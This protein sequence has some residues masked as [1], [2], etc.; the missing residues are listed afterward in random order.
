N[1]EKQHQRDGHN[2]LYCG[3]V[4]HDYLNCHCIYCAIEKE[5]C[6]HEHLFEYGYCLCGERDSTQ[7][8][9]IEIAYIN[10]LYEFNRRVNAGNYWLNARVVN[11]IIVNDCLLN[12]FGNLNPKIIKE[13]T[14]LGDYEHPYMGSFDGNRHTINGLYYKKNQSYA[15]FVAYNKGIIKNLGIKDSYFYSEYDYLGSIC[16]VNNGLIENCYNES[17]VVDGG[18]QPSNTAK[19][20]YVGGICGINNKT[21]TKCHNSS[22]V[23]AQDYLGGIAGLNNGEISLCYNISEN[24][25]GSNTIGGISGA[26][27][28]TIINCYNTGG[29]FGSQYMGGIS[30]LSENGS[31]ANCYNTGYILGWQIVDWIC[32]S[33]R[34]ECSIVNCYYNECNDVDEPEFA[35][36]E[37]AYKL[38]E[39][40]TTHV[41]GQRIGVDKYPQLMG[42]TIYYY[43]N[44]YTN[45][46]PSL[47]NCVSIAS[48]NN[49][50]AIY[51]LDRNI[52]VDNA[53]DTVI[54]NDINGITI[55]TKTG[56]SLQFEVQKIGIYVVIT[57]GKGYKV[58][59]K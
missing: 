31:I 58:I 13:W 25:H 47:D 54:L 30:G 27:K 33:T 50:P 29:V 41:W 1:I 5:D 6:E 59:I 36:G 51:T 38:Q 49:S 21:I 43:A 34:G 17:C 39:P 56:S 11:D 20:Y 46:P 10:D 14:P 4:M 37:I 2:C 16:G 45:T 9:W 42:D 28:N 32:G 24:I 22:S 23:V 52:Y 26:N 8:N 40:N 19:A 18:N 7:N 55:D 3:V 12:P 53:N 48:N 57:E 15:G 44:N 35:T